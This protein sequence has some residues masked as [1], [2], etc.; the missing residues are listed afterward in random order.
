MDQFIVLTWLEQVTG[1]DAASWVLFF[2]V[3]VAVCNYITRIIPDDET[4][5]LRTVKV[6]TRGIGLYTSNKVSKD[7]TVN[8]VA[9]TVIDAAPAVAEVA[10][11]K[12]KE[13][14]DEG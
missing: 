13:P 1:I 8:D 9:K 7:V 14:L 5:W 3:I 11:L 12:K 2:G 4:G 6:I 10:R